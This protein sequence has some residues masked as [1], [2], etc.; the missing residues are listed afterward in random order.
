MPNQKKLE[1]PKIWQPIPSQVTLWR[2]CDSGGVLPRHA[3]E[4]FQIVLS[5]AVAYKFDYRRNS[6][7][8]PPGCLGIIQTGEPHASQSEDATGET[9]RLMFVSPDYLQHVA[10][11]IACAV[12]IATTAPLVLPDLIV[13]EPQ[14]VRQFLQMHSSLEADATHLQRESLI[15]EFLTQLLLQC[16]ESPP[17]VPTAGQERRVVQLVREYLEDS[18]AENVSLEFLAN[19]VGL[20]PE[21]LVRVFTA[22]LGLPPHTYQTQVRISR[23][24]Q[25]LAAGYAIADIAH[26]TGF[27]D[28]AHFSRQFKRLNG[29]TPGTYRRHVKNVQDSS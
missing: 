9:L 24:K 8:L 20:S 3:H 6:H 14:L 22:E 15:W 10:N 17:K 27:V 29:V 26:Q 5:L 23:A 11:T 12:G 2:G 13:S 1:L 7:I 28:Q 25:L 4:E 16:A 19:I 18:Y 21:Y